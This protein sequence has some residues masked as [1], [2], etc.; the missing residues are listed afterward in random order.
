M[1][2]R[3]LVPWSAFAPLA[4]WAILALAA[5]AR[6]WRLDYHS[7]W[8][9]E[10]VSLQWAAS[11][12]DYTWRTTLALV[13]DKHPPAYYLLLHLWQQLLA[14]WNLAHND[15]ALRALGSLLGVLTAAGVL[16][17][18]SH[19]SGP[20]TGRLAALLV[21]LSPLLTWYSQ[22]LRMFQP[23]TTAIVGG[24]TCLW[25]AWH[26][27]SPRLRLLWWL[28]MIVALTFALYSYLFSAFVLPAAGLTLLW[29][30]LQAR[31]HTRFLEGVA[32]LALTGLLFLPLAATAW[33]VNA[34]EGTPSQPFADLGANLLRLLRVFTLWRTDWPAPLTATALILFAVLL[35][36]GLLL[37]ARRAAQG[38]RIW[39]GLW[40]GI[41]LL[42]ANLLLANSDSIFAEDRYLLFLA[43]FALWAIARGV[44]TLAER[45][46]RLG[47][48]AGVAATLALLLALP[49]LW[50]PAN[51]RENWRA[52]AQII[53]DY[54]A[55]APTLPAAVIAHIDY[56]NQPLQWYLRQQQPTLPVFFPFGG[57]LTPADI[58]TVIAPPLNGLVDFGAHTVWLAQSHLEGVDDQRL[59]EQWLSSRFPLITE[60]YPAGIKLTGYML[61]HRYTELP[62]LAPGTLYPDVELAPGL[63]LAACE[64]TTP[65]V[66]ARDEFLHP[67]SGW[68]HV[69]LWWQATTP[70]AMDYT[71]TA[72]VIGAA[73]VW[74]DRLHRPTDALRLSPT[75][76]WQPGEYRRDELDINLNPLTPAGLYPVIIGVADANGVSLGKTTSCGEVLIQ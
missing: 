61:R 31:R 4:P 12:M 63:R 5:L 45:A 41:P 6:F 58:D 33:S 40:L 43:P 51:A 20:T 55:A 8:F 52:A 56:V 9:D 16:R 28:G 30:Y 48:A 50:T 27:P 10:A 11:D 68:V 23:A 3:A 69:R 13:Q 34:T 7:I 67:P 17:L 1:N 38:G 47:R 64:I 2:R 49:P 18:V 35:L 59:V 42:I 75:S 66:P 25:A 24:A 54:N 32:A 62:P 72:Q 39:L 71:A 76:S 15:L 22:E 70:L 19:V 65:Q 74:G 57:A 26:A 37:P 46:P 29:L 36:L 21:A 53:S 14:Q 60:Q 44:I 73:G